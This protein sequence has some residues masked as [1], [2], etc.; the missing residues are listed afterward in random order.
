[1]DNAKPQLAGSALLLCHLQ[2]LPT[3]AIL[4]TS[5][6][7]IADS[8]AGAAARADHTHGRMM[9]VAYCRFAVRLRDAIA[10]AFLEL[11]AAVHV[12]QEVEVAVR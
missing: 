8:I 11:K 10:Q 9:R 5:G 3:H 1:M 6:T 2:V 7:A 12:Y 4:L